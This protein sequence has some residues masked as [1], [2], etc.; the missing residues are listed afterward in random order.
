MS[1]TLNMKEIPSVSVIEVVGYRVL[2]EERTSLLLAKREGEVP[3][4]P[5]PNLA[6][7]LGE[8]STS[9]QVVE[10]GEVVLLS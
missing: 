4:F 6:Q 1:E 8:S 9:H 5:D 7:A 10:L 2:E 3:R